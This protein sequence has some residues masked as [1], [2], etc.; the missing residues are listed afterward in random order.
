M[1]GAHLILLRHLPD[2]G[3]WLIIAS[4]ITSCSDSGAYF[5][6]SAI[7]KHK[8]C[9]NISPNKTV[10]GAIGGVVVGGVGAVTFAFLLLDDISW[11][12]LIISAI[13][14]TFAGIV[15]DLTESIIKRG[16]GTKDSGTC[17]AG[18]GGILDRGDSLLFAAPVLYYLLVFTGV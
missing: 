7:G 10:E 1:L 11:I 18:H 13:F 9:P 17:L 3:Y 14:L 4:A 16:T 12:F 5:I 8:L 2:G 15:G 6:G